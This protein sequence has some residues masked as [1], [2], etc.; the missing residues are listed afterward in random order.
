M[1]FSMTYLD[2]LDSWVSGLPKHGDQCCPDFSC[3]QP[4]LL[5]PKDVR[6][7]FVAAYKAKNESVTMRMLMEFLGRAFA[8][9][10]KAYIV[11]LD[12]I[13]EER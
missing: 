7:V 3:C 10:K 5:A 2:Q 6:E 11:G 9:G 1:T 8:T 12:A 4:D 13:R